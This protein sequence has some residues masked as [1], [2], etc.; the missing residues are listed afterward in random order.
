MYPITYEA[1][2]ERNPNRVTTFFRGILV[3]PWAIVGL[4]YA[5]AGF[6]TLIGAWIVV[7]ILGRY[8]DGLYNFNSGLLRYFIRIG[9]Y[10]S[11]QT[12]RWPPFGL[13]TDPTYPVRIEVA[14][15][16]ERHSRLKALGRYPFYILLVPI[17]TLV[18]FGMAA[19][20]WGAAAA[21]WLTI[22]FRGYLPAGAQNALMFTNGW[23]A[24]AG[25]YLLLLT[26]IYPPVG[27]EQTQ[28]G[29]VRPSA[30]AAP[31]AE[32]PRPPAPE[33]PPS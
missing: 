13:S 12:D 32:T 26:D 17:L 8:P 19:I 7:V 24:R 6:F 16:P 20:H 9:A 21:A 5:I 11:Y 29:D 3:I 27:A 33:A 2:Y 10:A 30:P 28:V 22:V 23:Y 18:Y 31:T 14:P 25:G 4:I 1:D 15:R